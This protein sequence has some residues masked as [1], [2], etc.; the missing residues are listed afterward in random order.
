MR[1]REVEKKGCCSAFFEEAVSGVLDVVAWGTVPGT[2]VAFDSADVGAMFDSGGVGATWGPTDSPRGVAAAAGFSPV[3]R[4]SWGAG[5]YCDAGGGATVGQLGTP[6]ARPGA[7][8]AVCPKATPQ[9]PPADARSAT[10]AATISPFSRLCRTVPPTVVEHYCRA[11]RLTMCAPPR[12]ATPATVRKMTVVPELLGGSPVAG[13]AFGTTGADPITPLYG[14]GVGA[15][16]GAGAGATGGA[17]TG[18]EMVGTLWPK[19]VPQLPPTAATRASTTAT[20]I[21]TP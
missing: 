1:R 12:S 11:R 14:V 4:V 19:A 15:T 21:D 7:G 9:L 13:R 8:G 17:G 6:G 3:V 20:E 5:R 2:D 16:V 18:V 10:A